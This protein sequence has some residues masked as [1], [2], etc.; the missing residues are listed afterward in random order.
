MER[1]AQDPYTN[2]CKIDSQ[3]EFAVWLR[4]LKPGLCDNLEGWDG[5][6]G[7]SEI[8]EGRDMYVPMADS[9]WCV[10]ETKTVL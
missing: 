2:M 6:G 3:W 10:A 8:Q 7:R 5:V 4:E 1:V 9:C